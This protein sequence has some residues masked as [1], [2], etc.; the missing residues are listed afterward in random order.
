VFFFLSK[1]LDELL[2]PLTWS[3]MLLAAAVP[4]RTRKPR[5]PRRDRAFAIAGFL[6]LFF[7]SLAP[8]EN[9]L[10]RWLE[11]SA[12]DT[13][14]PDVTYDA[15]ILLGGAVE[16]D[17][18]EEHGVPS[19][20]EHAERLLVTYDLL[21]T[22][23]ARYAIIT[24]GLAGGRINEAEVLKGQLAEWGIDPERIIEEGRA[25]NTRENA[26]FSAE[27]VKERGFDKL[28]LVTSAFHMKRAADCFRAIGLEPDTLPAD[29]RSSKEWSSLSF[30]PRSR[31]LDQSTYALREIFGRMVYR[32]NGYARPA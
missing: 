18:T 28:V 32:I 29:W 2:S 24:G 3:A 25:M 31:Y 23:R 15:V 11:S 16:G 8:V 10:T 20:N 19:Y 14:K 27:I 17:P 30:L 26:V 12:K 22:G 21:R 13:T 1:L 9:A 4:W 6:V 5:R 7:F